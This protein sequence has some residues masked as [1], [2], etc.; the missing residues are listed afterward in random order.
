MNDALY[1][2]MKNLKSKQEVML[3]ETGVYRDFVCVNDVGMLITPDVI[4]EQFRKLLDR[5]GLP[6][7]KFH[8]LRHSASVFLLIIRLSQ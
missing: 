3:R 6:H 7:I 5:N 1:R 4:T 8:A 2:Y